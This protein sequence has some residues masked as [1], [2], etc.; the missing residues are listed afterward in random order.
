MTSSRGCSA[1]GAVS[2]NGNIDCRWQSILSS[3]THLVGNHLYTHEALTWKSSDLKNLT[4][5][6]F[7]RLM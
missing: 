6:L 3:N 1:E 7:E 2:G 5:L 4:A